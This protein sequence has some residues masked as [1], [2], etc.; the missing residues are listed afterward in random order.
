MIVLKQ[1][2]K[3]FVLFKKDV[4]YVINEKKIVIVDELTGR[5][6]PGRRFSEG[7]HESIE[8]KE[9]VEVQQESQTHATI[10]LQNYFKMYDKI[11]RYDRNSKNRRK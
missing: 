7:I 6:M 2:L 9:R 10:T 3:A 8:A 4:D 5:M 1:L 11:K